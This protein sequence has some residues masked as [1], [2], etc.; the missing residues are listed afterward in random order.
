MRRPPAWI[1][2]GAVAFVLVVVARFP[3]RWA[4]PALPRGIA[5]E[6]IAGTVWNGTCTGLLATREPL[7]NLRWTLHPLRLL[8]GKLS[9][10]M[11]LARAGGSARARVD[12]SPSG[13]ITARDLEARF[14]LEGELLQGLPPATR[15]TVEAHLGELRWSHYRITKI[16]GMIE[17]LGLTARGEPLGDY[18]LTFPASRVGDEPEGRLSDLGGPFAVQGILRLSRDGGYVVSGSIAARPDASPDLAA[19]LRYLGSPDAQGR[20]R[21]S[22]AGAF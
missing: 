8:A 1:A 19:Q 15:G 12:F 13:S 4:A 3:A 6:R 20:R 9:L 18:R 21:F 7:G 10:Q 14:A 11:T 16:T 22:V 5:C 17:V 2:A